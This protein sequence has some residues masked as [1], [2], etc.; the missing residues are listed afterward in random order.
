MYHHIV[1]QT[2]DYLDSNEKNQISQGNPANIILA[3][4]GQLKDFLVG[5][6]H[7]V[8]KHD[9]IKESNTCV[10]KKYGCNEKEKRF[11]MDVASV[12]VINQMMT[13]EIAS[14]KENRIV[15]QSDID[16]TVEWS[17]TW[18][19]AMKQQKKKRKKALFVDEKKKIQCTKRVRKKRANFY[20]KYHD[21]SAKAKPISP[22]FYDPE[23][24]GD[25]NTDDY[26]DAF[27]V[28]QF[29]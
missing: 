11:L 6:E 10:N 29:I 23:L 20:R 1:S 22:H 15:K 13:E 26:V 2:Q 4:D 16:L 27:D 9:S 5:R 8:T 24:N 17:K 19:K 18:E 25:P 12:K 14:Y 21:F 7:P 28:N 3:P